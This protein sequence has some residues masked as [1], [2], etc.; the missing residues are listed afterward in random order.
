MAFPSSENV[1][2]DAILRYGFIVRDVRKHMSD[3]VENPWERRHLAC[4]LSL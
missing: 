1:A 4:L 3:S 2:Q